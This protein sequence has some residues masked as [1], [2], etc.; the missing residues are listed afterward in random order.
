MYPVSAEYLT[1]ITKNARAHVLRGA[2][3]GTSFEGSDVIKGS[4]SLT[5]Q[6]CPATS[7]ELG[8]VYV[9]QLN[10]T[11][12]MN[13]ATSMNIRGSWRGV[14]IAAEVGV[15]LAG[16]TFEYIPI[17]GGTYTIESA[18]WTDNGLKIVAYDSMQKFD[19]PIQMT[20][21]AGDLFGFLSL[22]CSFCDVTLGMSQ[23]DC[24]AF[25]NGS[26]TLSMA[27]GTPIGTWRDMISQIAAACCAFATIDREGQLI[28]KKFPNYDKIV[29]RINDRQRYSTNFSDHASFY[30]DVQVENLDD[31]TI[32]LYFNENQS[33]LTMDL[34]GNAFL[35]SGDKD[36]LRQAIADGLKDLI[37]TPFSVTILPNPALDLGDLIQFTGG[38]G[39]GSGGIVMSYTLKVDSMTLEGYG[40]N[41]AIVGAASALQKQV[42]ANARNQKGNELIFKRVVSAH[43]I[44]IDTTGT[45]LYEIDFAVGDTTDVNIW[46]EFKELNV[47]EGDS[48]SIQL[49]YYYDDE[50]QNYSPID[51]Y[52]ES[53]KYHTQKGDY[54]RANVPSGDVHT[55][56]VEARTDSGTAVIRLGDLRATL[57]GQ[58][59]V[60]VKTGGN[61]E[62]TEDYTVKALG[63]PRPVGLIEGE[64]VVDDG[65]GQGGFLLLES[66]GYLLLESGGRIKLEEAE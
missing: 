3:D 1:A 22:A 37:S 50:L 25:V 7:I 43:D 47:F 40:E 62:I 2:V 19:L 60:A 53:G 63:T 56:R 26:N 36:T 34:G 42:A 35:Q 6:I 55:W 29:A 27:L 45:V 57:W 13:F 5:N 20:N 10:L 61:I 24:A 23:D 17:P 12:S 66:G 38:I 31:G 52:C 64:V 59:V 21:S 51:T 18:Q 41:P 33:A 39:Q 11:F 65:S 28:L 8:G 9:G 46:H 48:Q 32:D 15:E 30:S 14:E 58:K 16:G 49:Y 54:W 4:F 44:T